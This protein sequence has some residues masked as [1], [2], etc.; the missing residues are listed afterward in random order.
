[1]L[2]FF[3]L[4]F[5]SIKQGI[6]VHKSSHN[7]WQWSMKKILMSC[8]NLILFDQIEAS[9]YLPIKIQ[10]FWWWYCTPQLTFLA[11]SSHDNC[12]KLWKCGN[13][14]M[15]KFSQS[16]QALLMLLNLGFDGSS[17]ILTLIA[18]LQFTLLRRFWCNF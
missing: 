15:R 7:F 14:D 6:F 4:F 17:Y 13:K 8:E 9:H 11:I 5:C 1:M 12:Q 3:P 10:S 2:P 18:L 16:Q